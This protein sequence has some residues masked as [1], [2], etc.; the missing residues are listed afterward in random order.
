MEQHHSG[1][2]APSG[3]AT[4]M[5]K[6][7]KCM[8]AVAMFFV[9]P[10]AAKY[11]RPEMHSYLL[12]EFGYSIAY[13]GSWAFVAVVIGGAFFLTSTFLELIILAVIRWFANRGGL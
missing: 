3:I 11:L 13:W 1:G 2:A 7:S 4:N 12:S 9:A 8:G 6:F 5:G 10:Q